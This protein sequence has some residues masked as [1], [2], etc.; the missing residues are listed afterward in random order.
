MMMSF[1]L[2]HVNNAGGRKKIGKKELM[3]IVASATQTH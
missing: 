1:L 3:V 2:H